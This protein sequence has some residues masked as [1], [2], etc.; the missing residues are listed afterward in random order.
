MDHRHRRG[1]GGDPRLRKRGIEF[2]SLHEALDT[3]T[4]GGRLVF[5]VF[6][7]LAEFIRE[8]SVQG[9]NEGLAY[10]LGSEQ[11]PG[12][13]HT[14]NRRV[15]TFPDAIVLYWVHDSV[16]TITAVDIIH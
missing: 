16:L 9:T 7:A 11:A 6:A 3:T 15:V 4:P 2:T 8:L 1:A 5:H 13:P 12:R 10:E 14:K